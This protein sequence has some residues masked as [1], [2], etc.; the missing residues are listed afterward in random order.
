M[1]EVTEVRGAY[2]V[3]DRDAVARCVPSI[4]MLEIFLDEIAECLRHDSKL[5]HCSLLRFF[6]LG[7][8]DPTTTANNFSERQNDRVDV[9]DLTIVLRIKVSV[10]DAEHM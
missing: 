1:H 4:V 6:S 5:V 8:K 9:H 10:P 7:E 3:G 2:K